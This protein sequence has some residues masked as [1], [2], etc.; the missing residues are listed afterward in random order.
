MIQAMVVIE[1]KKTKIL[2]INSLYDK[3]LKDFI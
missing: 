2:S 3:N 1:F